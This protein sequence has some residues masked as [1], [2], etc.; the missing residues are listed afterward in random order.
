MFT[1]TPSQLFRKISFLLSL[2]GK[3][4]YLAIHLK[5]EVGQFIFLINSIV[6]NLIYGLW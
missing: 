3:P 5:E 2:C 6:S 4:T 1:I